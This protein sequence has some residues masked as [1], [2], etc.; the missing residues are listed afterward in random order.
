MGRITES[1][2]DAA[3]RDLALQDT[4]GTYWMIGANTGAW[5]YFDGTNWLPG[6]PSTARFGVPTMPEPQATAPQFD[7]PTVPQPQT[8]TSHL[9][10]PP[11]PQPQAAG[12]SAPLYAEPK[13]RTAH[14]LALPFFVTGFVLV[15]VGAIA[16]WLF[17]GDLSAVTAAQPAATRIVAATAVAIVP[18][19]AI[20]SQATETPTPGASGDTNAAAVPTRITPPAFVVPPTDTVPALSTIP[21]VT[22][23]ARV[24]A[25]AAAQDSSQ[26]APLT[27]ASFP[28]PPASVPP[29]SLPPDVYITN[30]TASPNPPHQRQDI[31][32]TV[33]F[34]NTNPSSVGME[35]RIVFLNPN[36][37]GRNKDWGQ[38]QLVGAQV[39]P[40][41]SQLSLVFTPVTSTG[42]CV[43][44]QVLAARR[45]Q[46][47]GRFLL[48]GT[49]GGTFSTMMTFC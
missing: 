46:D 14:G 36:K 17:N 39:P 22:P 5:Y 21:T 48:P 42:P 18:S 15:L 32:F 2:F 45:L 28:V 26:G 1:Q 47:G 12:A 10:T 27:D 37:T 8:S 20:S 38:S 24:R 49:G 13:P 44:L 43:P 30:I 23:G 7:A 11:V 34:L 19:P 9:Y 33:S 4:Q 6:D 31:T 41:A 29:G 25:T 3:L 16:F 40:G 35:W